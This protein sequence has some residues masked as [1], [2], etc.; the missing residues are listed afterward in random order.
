MRKHRKRVGQSFQ[1]KIPHGTFCFIT[2]VCTHI[3]MCV[4]IHA[5]LSVFP[6][7]IPLYL[8]RCIY[9]LHAYI[10]TC[11]R[12]TNNNVNRVCVYT[13]S[14]THSHIH[15]HTHTHTHVIFFFWLGTG[16]A[17]SYARRQDG[18][19]RTDIQMRKGAFWKGKARAGGDGQIHER[20]HFSRKS[21]PRHL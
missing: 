7:S 1:I 3:C 5:Y 15:T 2:Y 18:C 13:H 14:L 6:L 19:T 9:T 8:H 21:A 4:L 16:G 11:T 17:E 12:V 10:H 20:T